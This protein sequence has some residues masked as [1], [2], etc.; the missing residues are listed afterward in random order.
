MVNQASLGFVRNHA[1][2]HLYIKNGKVNL[3]TGTINIEFDKEKYKKISESKEAESLAKL[4]FDDL[5]K[6]YGERKAQIIM[7]FSNELEKKREI[8]FN[9]VDS[10]KRELI[11]DFQD[12]GWRCFKQ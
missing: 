5:N 11:R 1:V 12:S 10:L 9:D 4:D 3:I 7:E 8:D 6:Q 2:M